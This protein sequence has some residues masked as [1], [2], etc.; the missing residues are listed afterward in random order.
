M[1]RECC[2]EGAL[3]SQEGLGSETTESRVVTTSIIPGLVFLQDLMEM[4][5][6]DLVNPWSLQ[7]VVMSG[8]QMDET[9]GLW[10]MGGTSSNVPSLFWVTSLKLPNP[11][12]PERLI[13]KLLHTTHHSRWALRFGCPHRTEFP[14]GRNCVIPKSSSAPWCTSTAGAHTHK[15]FLK[16]VRIL[17]FLKKASKSLL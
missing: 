15:I 3:V 9:Q 13:L 5:S 17:T 8:C 12:A 4:S 1:F 7:G 2:L 6:P 10:N 14:E 16:E 11:C